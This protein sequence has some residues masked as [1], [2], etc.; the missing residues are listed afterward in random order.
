ME[1]PLN[2]PPDS[3]LDNISL[4]DDLSKEILKKYD[5]PKAFNKIGFARP[6]GGLFYQYFYGILSGVIILLTYSFILKWLYP[7]PDA[8]AYGKVAEKLFSFLFFVLNIPTAFSL[9]RF[10]AEWRVKNPYKMV[11]YIRFYIWYQMITGLVLVLSTSVYV[12]YIMKTGNLLYAKFL[13]LVYISREYPAMT[14]VFLATLRGLQQF[15]KEA[16]IN[17]IADI[18]IKP[19]CEITC[20]LLG[21]YVLGSNPKFGPLMGIAIGY[22]VGT[23]IDDF[24]TMLISGAYLDK[25]LHNYGF[26]IWDCVVPYVEKDVWVTSLKF[27]LSLSPPGIISSLLGFFAFFWWYDLVPAYAT[28]IVLNDTADQLGNMIKRAGGLY[29]KPVI[30]ESLNNKKVHL[31]RYYIGMTLK[32]NYWLM[33]GMLAIMVSFMP[34]ILELLLTG[35]GTENWLLAV[36]FITPNF[37]AS[38]LEP[39][40]SLTGDVILGGN[41]PL[42]HSIMNISSNLLG[43]GLDILLL[44]VFQIPQKMGITGLIWL[45]PLKGMPL[46]ILRLTADWI[47]IQKK[48][49]KMRFRDF[50]WQTFVAPLPAMLLLIGLAQ[51]WFAFAYPWLNSITN[52]YVTAG[53][54]IIFGIFCL[55]WVYFPVYALFGGW[56]DYNIKIFHE[57]VEISGPSKFLFKPIDWANRGI[58]KYS[59]LHNR[60]PIPWKIADKEAEDLMKEAFVKEKLSAMMNQ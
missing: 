3:N 24:I 53:S 37:I 35:D 21:R 28:L 4:D 60:F 58:I 19:I 20:V 27:G 42:W 30:S 34:I 5:P 47:F 31:T 39:L 44:F 2:I 33:F 49:V 14:G 52:I 32:I 57:A 11:Q 18:S 8:K 13:L 29:M 36:A 23:Y 22:A 10:A 41:K 54:S 50:A 38:T 59:K 26:T 15:D 46:T 6:L 12:L 48:L 55:L 25:Y 43:I 45:I 9:E 16:K 40:G 1:E 56:D 7:Y 51:L 17:F